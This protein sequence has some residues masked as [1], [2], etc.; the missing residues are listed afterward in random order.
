[1]LC[2]ASVGPALN[3]IKQKPRR[4]AASGFVSFEAWGRVWTDAPGPL[5]ENQ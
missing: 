2:A 5:Y 3:S 4:V 1:M